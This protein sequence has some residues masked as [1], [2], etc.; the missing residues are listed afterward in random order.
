MK[1][2]NS[3]RLYEWQILK[4]ETEKNQNILIL[5]HNLKLETGKEVSD[6][7]LTKFPL[8]FPTLLKFK[9]DCTFHIEAKKAAHTFKGQNET[10]HLNS[11]TKSLF[12]DDKLWRLRIDLKFCSQNFYY[13]Q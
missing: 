2:I 1:Q 8:H 9:D 7:L 12:G 4:W 10:M 11:R 3:N 5:R 13:Y 6:F